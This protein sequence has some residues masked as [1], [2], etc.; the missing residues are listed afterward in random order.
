MQFDDFVT[1]VRSCYQGSRLSKETL[2]RIHQAAQESWGLG[3]RAVGSKV[4]LELAMQ[5]QRFVADQIAVLDEQ[6]L[7]L[8]A[9]TGYAQIA[10]TMPGM[11]SSSAATLLRS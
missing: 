7:D 1:E 3:A 6:L 10:E 11:T 2:R 4:R 5:R 8:Y 9:R